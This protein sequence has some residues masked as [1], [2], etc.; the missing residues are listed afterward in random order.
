MEVADLCTFRMNMFRGLHCSCAPIRSSILHSVEA[1]VSRHP[2]DASFANCVKSYALRLGSRQG[3]SCTLCVQ[4][5]KDWF[6]DV[7]FR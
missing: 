1:Q 2:G 5:V 4:G 7:V 6:L 3:G